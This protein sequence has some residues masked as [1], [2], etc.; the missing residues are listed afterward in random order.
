MLV[1]V[2]G[3][4]DRVIYLRACT[5]DCSNI[6]TLNSLS[7][8]SFQTF[9]FASTRQKY[10]TLCL[11]PAEENYIAAMFRRNNLYAN[12]ICS[13]WLSFVPQSRNPIHPLREDFQ[14]FWLSNNNNEMIEKYSRT[15][16]RR[17]KCVLSLKL[18]FSYSV[19]RYLH[20]SPTRQTM[21]KMFRL[22]PAELV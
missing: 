11:L 2:V 6:S 17:T 9:F 8:A 12:S 14:S 20:N 18:A 4:S 5:P 16:P 19:S 13:V 21:N 3:F 10:D 15:K 7:N 1:F 22:L